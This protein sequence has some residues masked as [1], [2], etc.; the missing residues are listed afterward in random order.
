MGS[1]LAAKVRTAVRQP[2]CRGRSRCSA[3]LPCAAPGNLQRAGGRGGGQEDGQAG[4]GQAGSRPLHRW[5]SAGSLPVA[6]R[7]LRVCHQRR[8]ELSAAVR[9]LLLS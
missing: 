3:R 6:E 9:Q 5:S 1:R 8:L 7:G 2:G 4:R